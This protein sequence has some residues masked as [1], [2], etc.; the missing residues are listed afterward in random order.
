VCRVSKHATGVV[1][2]NLLKKGVV[3]L[4]VGEREETLY[5]VVLFEVSKATVETGVLQTML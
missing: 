4:L 3:D 2:E 5:Y 1:D